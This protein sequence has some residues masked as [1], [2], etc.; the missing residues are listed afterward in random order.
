MLNLTPPFL[1]I[2][3]GRQ[4]SG[5]SHLIKYI[6]REN[7]ISDTPFHYGIVFSNTAGFEGSHKYIPKEYIF[8]RFEPLAV[9]N[10]MDIQKGLTKKKRK[11]KCA[12]ILFDDCLDDYKQF[13]N[14]YIKKLSTQ[15]RHYNIS[16]LISTQYPHLIPPR[17]RSNS[18]YVFILQVGSGRREL[19]SIYDCYA[20]QFSNYEEFKKF[21]YENIKDHKFF[22]YDNETDS[23]ITYRAPEKIPKFKLKYRTK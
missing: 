20:N 15:L 1:L 7:S 2:I 3:N 9:R 14:E 22:C 17:V 4:G 6:F 11:K 21:Y 13:S 18:M 23:F 12:F 8:D 10:L 16:M 5:K 19:S